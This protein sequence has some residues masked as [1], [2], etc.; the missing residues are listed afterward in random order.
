MELNDLVEK[1]QKNHINHPAYLKVKQIMDLLV[2]I[3]SSL[4]TFGV[5]TTKN[6]VKLSH[7]KNI[8]RGK[9]AF[10]IGMGPSLKIED[11]AKLRREITFAC[12]KVYLAFEKTNWRP[13]YYSVLDILIAQNN[14]TIIEKLNLKKIFSK[15][16]TPYFPRSKD[17][18]WLKELHA[19]ACNGIQTFQFSTNALHGLYGGWTVLYS[20]LQL[21]FY[22]GIREIYLIGVDFS[23][24]IPKHEAGECMHGRV[25]VNGEENNHFHQDYRAV[26]ETWT[27]PRLDLQYRAFQC[28]REVFKKYNGIIYNASRQTKLDVFPIVNFD[29][30]NLA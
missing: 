16:V 28:A 7:L 27:M 18:I 23:F 30:L 13:T 10:I 9:R 19:P 15:C 3:H 4:N 14:S 20:Q 17:I 12:N 8:H 2:K 26:G 25:L 11:L 29:Q 6:E 22:M 1:I 5:P 21:A 24:N